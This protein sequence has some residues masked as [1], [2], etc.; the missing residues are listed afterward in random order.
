MIPW[1]HCPRSRGNRA[2]DPVESLPMMVWN[3]QPYSR[4]LPRGRL[5]RGLVHRLDGRYAG[6]DRRE[7]LADEL[8]HLAGL[9]GLGIAK[10]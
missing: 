4:T 7:Q 9:I 5:T 3:T 10:I 8:D 6:Q 1:N 2:H